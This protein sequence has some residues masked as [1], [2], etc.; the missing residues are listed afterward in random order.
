M[1]SE[2]LENGLIST[3]ILWEF[4]DKI[5]ALPKTNAEAVT[6]ILH[7]EEQL[8]NDGL[9]EL[10]EVFNITFKECIRNKN[11]GF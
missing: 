4:C 9:Q 10:N 6:S 11:I 3:G 5:S 7:K 1:Y 8:I 2:K